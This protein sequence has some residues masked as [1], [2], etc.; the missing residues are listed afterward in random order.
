M[1]THS[2]DNKEKLICAFC[3][4][5]FT[6][7]MIEVYEGTYGCETGCTT[8]EVRVQCER[9]GATC[10]EK[11]ELGGVYKETTDEEWA[12]IIKKAKSNEI[13]IKYHA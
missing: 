2:S 8:V 5:P 1:S 13:D 11:S 3:S 10:Y 9:C 4:A 12:E 6:K 7:E